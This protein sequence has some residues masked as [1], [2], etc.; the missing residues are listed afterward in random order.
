[1]GALG[2][3][4]RSTGAGSGGSGAA[5][6]DGTVIAGAVGLGAGTAGA[7]GG[8][9]TKIGFGF[10]TAGTVAGAAG[11]VATCAT[12]G[13]AGIVVGGSGSAAAGADAAATLARARSG[14]ISAGA[15][16]PGE[17][18]SAGRKSD[19]TVA[20]RS[21]LADV[22]G[23]AGAAA[24]PLPAVDS[25]VGATSFGRIRSRGIGSAALADE[26]DSRLGVAAGTTSVARAGVS[27]PTTDPS[28]AAR[29]LGFSLS[30][31]AG[32]WSSLMG[33][34]RTWIRHAT[35][36]K[37]VCLALLTHRFHV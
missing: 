35:E 22:L 11:G 33:G 9:V 16:A 15:A 6:G 23:A 21:T 25:P 29:S 24:P 1:M 5:P 30:D 26:V 19:G 13:A 28:F 31:G 4:G 12:A 7:G 36:V 37:K 17:L 27:S 18:C 2:S 10:A 34:K 14:G 32:V 20:G 3:A 8:V